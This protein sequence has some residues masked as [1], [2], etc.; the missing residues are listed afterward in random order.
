MQKVLRNF[1]NLVIILLV[2][3]VIKR[4]IEKTNLVSGFFI[5][6]VLTSVQ[7]TIVLA[8]LFIPLLFRVCKKAVNQPKKAWGGAVLLFI[9]GFGCTEALC[10][11]WFHHPEHVPA[12]MKDAYALYYEFYGRNIIQFDSKC[13]AYNPQLFYTLKP[14]SR[15]SFSNAEF[16]TRYRTNSMGVRDD[17]SSLNKPDVICLGDS[18]TMGWGVEQDSTFS[19]RLEKVSGEKILNTGISSYGTAREIMNLSRFDTS[20]L[21]Y[22]VVQYCEN[23]YEENELY[24]EN[25]FV[26]K[27]S[28]QQKYDSIVK[29]KEISSV[30]YPGKRFLNVL[31]L[32]I[33][34]RVNKIVHVFPLDNEN[35]IDEESIRVQAK[36]FLNVLG[37]AGIEFSK[38]KIIVLYPTPNFSLNRSFE[39]ITDSLIHESPYKERFGNNINILKLSELLQP[40]DY[41]M[42][43]THLNNKGHRKVAGFIW[44]MMQSF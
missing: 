2:I 17:E 9:I 39:R 20:S 14:N 21:K 11:S 40:D 37:R 43:D 5:S 6:V 41:Y 38:R 23:D 10:T 1:L 44:K 35:T 30:Y 42:L 8:F 26:L 16:N 36:S 24:L 4:S 3:E 27:I 19:Q 29:T 32:W 18:F 34:L 7:M 22:L 12:F 28:S 15:F 13:S 25:H 33:K 31:Q